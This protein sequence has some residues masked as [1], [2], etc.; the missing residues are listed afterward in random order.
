MYIRMICMILY[1]YMCDMHVQHILLWYAYVQVSEAASEQAPW[2]WGPSSCTTF[3]KWLGRQQP[4]PS[5]QWVAW[6]EA[7]ADFLRLFKKEELDSYHRLHAELSRH[8]L[9]SGTEG[10]T[11]GYFHLQCDRS[12]HA[13]ADGWAGGAALH[14]YG[15]DSVWACPRSEVYTWL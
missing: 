1:I 3:C 14:P 5:W 2:H 6:H 10:G 7:V 11:E 15:G 13:A 4:W 12:R 8:L 9:L